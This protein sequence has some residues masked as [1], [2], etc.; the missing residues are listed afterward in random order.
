MAMNPR[1][2]RPLD[3]RFSPKNISGLAL[4]LDATDSASTVIDTGVTTWKDKSGNGRDFT[5]TT[6][7][8]QPTLTT[9]NGK[10]ALSFNGSSTQMTRTSV[11]PSSVID[12]TGVAS[13]IVYAPSS[14]TTYSVFHPGGSVAH[15]DRFSDGNSFTSTWRAN[16]FSAILFNKMPSNAAGLLVH[17]HNA[18]SHLIRINKVQE[19]SGS[20]DFTNYRALSAGTWIIGNGPNNDFLNG[21]VAEI[22]V[23]GREIS[24]TEVARV[25]KYLATKWGL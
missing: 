11:T 22:V 10:T 17:Q 6:G 16:R 9:L 7:A 19:Y 20:S 15:R 25:E 1:L 13:F 18:S 8:N 4:W 3:T 2:L 21:T 24:A 12:S 5:Q 23:Y 14:D